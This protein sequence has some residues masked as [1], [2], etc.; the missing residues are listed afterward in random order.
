[1]MN[2]EFFH[3]YITF[4]VIA[5]TVSIQFRIVFVFGKSLL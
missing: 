3:E 4:D 5:G 1:M 2:D